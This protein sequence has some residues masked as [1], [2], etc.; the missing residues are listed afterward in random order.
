MTRNGTR[1]SLLVSTLGNW[2]SSENIDGSRKN[3]ITM[4]LSR[5]GLRTP[6][7]PFHGGF[8]SLTCYSYSFTVF[9]PRHS[10]HTLVQ[11][12]YLSAVF[13]LTY[14]VY[15]C[16]QCAHLGEVFVDALLFS[17]N[18]QASAVYLLDPKERT[19]SPDRGVMRITVASAGCCPGSRAQEE[20]SCHITNA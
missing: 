19:E 4:K 5:E 10:V 14:S 1:T 18:D 13:M 11:Y 20:A 8:Y 6:R 3:H 7:H 15:T 17:N 2:C 12:S 9:L 16:V